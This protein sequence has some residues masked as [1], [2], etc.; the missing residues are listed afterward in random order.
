LEGV[1]FLS[2]KGRVDPF[3]IK[4]VRLSGGAYLILGCF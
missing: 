3:E 1:V 2:K 4:I